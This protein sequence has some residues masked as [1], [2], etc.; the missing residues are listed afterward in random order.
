MNFDS[1]LYLEVT[2]VLAGLVDLAPVQEM[3][4]VH[5][6]TGEIRLK[7]SLRF[8]AFFF[9]ADFLLMYLILNTKYVK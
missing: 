2:P 6:P 5:H 1:H 7:K 4:V 3:V 9:F 8:F